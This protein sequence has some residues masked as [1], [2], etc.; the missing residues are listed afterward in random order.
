[1]FIWDTAIE[2]LNKLLDIY[3]EQSSPQFQY[4]K[5]INQVYKSYISAKKEVDYLDNK[6]KKEL[7]KDEPNDNDI[8]V[9]MLKRQKTIE[10]AN[11]LEQQLTELYKMKD[12]ILAKDNNNNNN[13]FT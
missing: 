12:I 1:M 3:K 9:L 4:K 8:S 5:K 13:F 7:L 2:T 10:I 11:Q 6:I